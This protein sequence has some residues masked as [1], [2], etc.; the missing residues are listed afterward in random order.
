MQEM[1]IMTFIQVVMMTRLRL[2]Q[3]MTLSPQGTGMITSLLELVMTPLPQDQ[4]MTSLK[5]ELVMTLLR[6]I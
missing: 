1:E 4:V 6:G 5:P 3:E 2:E